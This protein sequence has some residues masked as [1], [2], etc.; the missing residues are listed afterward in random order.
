MVLLLVFE[1]CHAFPAPTMRE[2]SEIRKMPTIAIEDNNKKK[3]LWYRYCFK[4][5]RNIFPRGDRLK[6][7]GT[8]MPRRNSHVEYHSG[9]SGTKQPGT[10]DGRRKAYWNFKL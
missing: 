1:D 9:T 6:Q 2:R 7:N 3:A 4:I 8:K 10:D 5:S